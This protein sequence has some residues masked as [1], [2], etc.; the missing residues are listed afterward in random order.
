MSSDVMRAK[1][2]FRF[3]DESTSPGKHLLFAPIARSRGAVDVSLASNLPEDVFLHTAKKGL[4]QLKS[5]V[6]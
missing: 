3:K 5:P 2:K 6:I 1:K 4:R